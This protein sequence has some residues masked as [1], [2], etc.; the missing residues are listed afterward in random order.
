[1]AGEVAGAPALTQRRSVPYQLERPSDSVVEFDARALFGKGWQLD[2]ANSFVSTELGYRLR[3]GGQ[4]DEVRL[5][6]VTGLE[7]WDGILGLLTVSAAVPFGGDREASLEITP[8]IAFTLWPSLG[9]NDKKPDLKTPPQAL[10]IGVGVDALR[11]DDG[12]RIS[13]GIWT[14]F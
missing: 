6:G 2:W 9:A 3:H 5:D 12:I 14:R 11:P 7:P 1:M 4:A 8:S 10:Q 13:A